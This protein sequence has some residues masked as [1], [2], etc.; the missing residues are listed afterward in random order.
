[1]RTRGA[2]QVRQEFVTVVVPARHP[3]KDRVGDTL[4]IPIYQD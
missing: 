3:T 1:L 4:N 2:H